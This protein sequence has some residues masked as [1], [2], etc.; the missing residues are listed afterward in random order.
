MATERMAQHLRHVHREPGLAT[1][2][3]SLNRLATASDAGWHALVTNPGPPA[4]SASASL[5]ANAMVGRI[6]PDEIAG[7]S[8]PVKWLMNRVESPGDTE[9]LALL[10]NTA[11]PSID[12]GTAVPVNAIAEL[13]DR[14]T[15]V[16][17]HAAS[18]EVHL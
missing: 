1:S 2:A 3:K 7:A 18:A 10:S 17:A 6:A 4:I 11:H 13:L 14:A 12:T 5:P 8:V 16:P 9:R 15:G